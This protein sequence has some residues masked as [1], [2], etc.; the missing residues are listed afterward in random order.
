MLKNILRGFRRAPRKSALELV[1]HQRDQLASL[2]D[3]ALKAVEN[4]FAKAAVTSERVLGLRPH[5]EQILGAIA[6]A[7]GS[8]AEMQTGE[9]KTLTAVLAVAE[10]ARASPVHVLTANDYL[11]RRDAEWMGG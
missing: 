5:D 11:A 9:G 7:G 6:M 8:I 2:S 3:E 10:L 1:L 4:S